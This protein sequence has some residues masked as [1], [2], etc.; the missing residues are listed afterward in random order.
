[1]VK[2]WFELHYGRYLVR[3]DVLKS[4]PAKVRSQFGLCWP[5]LRIFINTGNDWF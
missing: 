3:K 2:N 5:F 1:M 4:L